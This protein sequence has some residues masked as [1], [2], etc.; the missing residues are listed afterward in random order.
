MMEGRKAGMARTR[1]G[2]SLFEE[3][4]EERRETR[5]GRNYNMAS[6]FAFLALCRF[7]KGRKNRG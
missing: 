2:G 4:R 6:L 7:F 5:A 1:G 3:P